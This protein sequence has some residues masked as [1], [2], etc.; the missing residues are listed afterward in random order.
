MKEMFHTCYGNGLTKGTIIQIFYRGLDDPTQGIIDAG[1]IFLYKTPNETFKILEDKV[2]LKL[3]FSKDPHIKPEPK[4]VVSTNGSNINSY[5]EIFKE[6]LIA[7]ATKINSEFIIIRNELLEMR[8]SRRDNKAS[9]I[10]IKDDTSMCEPQEENY[11]LKSI[12]GAGN[13]IL[14]KKE[15]KKDDNSVPK[16]LN[17]EQKLNEKAVLHNKDVYHC[18]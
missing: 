2:L 15:I 3:N 14:T 9:Q 7:L 12:D 11:E 13:G 8:D 17:K 10:Y 18:Q 16:E 1:G 6:K 5:H 4:I